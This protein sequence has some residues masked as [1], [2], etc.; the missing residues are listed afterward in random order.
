MAI[1][2]TC[3]M[4]VYQAARWA[5]CNAVKQWCSEPTNIL[6]PVKPLHISECPQHFSAGALALLSMSHMWL[7]RAKRQKLP[8]QHQSY[9]PCRLLQ[10]LLIIAQHSALSEIINRASA[11]WIYKSQESSWKL[12]PCSRRISITWGPLVSFIAED[13]CNHNLVW[14]GHV[15]N[16]QSKKFHLKWLNIFQQTQILW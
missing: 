10:E 14:T 3:I 9:R 1:I 16:W 2:Y 15:C 5:Q 11:Q 6:T 4:P 7:Q 8:A 13:I 12:K